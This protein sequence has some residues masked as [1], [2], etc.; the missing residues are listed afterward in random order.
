MS[1]RLEESLTLSKAISRASSALASARRPSPVIAAARENAA[2]RG[3]KHN[4][5]D[6]GRR[7]RRR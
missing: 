1:G 6:S 4:H 2:G 3:A 7:D 5:R